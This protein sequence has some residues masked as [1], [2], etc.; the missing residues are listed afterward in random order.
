[1]EESI[2]TSG[3]AGLVGSM[4]LAVALAWFAGRAFKGLFGKEGP[5]RDGR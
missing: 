3:E 2:W 4:L 1:M 5:W